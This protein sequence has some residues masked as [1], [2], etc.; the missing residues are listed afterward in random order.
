MPITTSH[1]TTHLNFL[2]RVTEFINNSRLT[3][4]KTETYF[5]NRVGELRAL[6]QRG[7]PWVFLCASSFL[8]YLAKI[9]LGKTTTSTDYKNFLT[10]YLFKV[11]PAYGA[12]RFHSGAQDLAEQ[13]YHVL[14]CGVVHSFSLFADPA[15]KTKHGGRDRSILLAH[16]GSG[17]HHLANYVKQRTKPQVDAAVFVAEDFVDDVGK[18]TE[19]LFAQARKRNMTGKRL[20]NNIQTWVK[21]YPPVGMRMY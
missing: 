18:V 10:N 2:R 5:K 9:E 7:D 17:Q 3:L 15:A 21:S 20:R 16:R 11:C 12:F 13:M 14:R 19:F 1:H 6:A 8:E 4:T